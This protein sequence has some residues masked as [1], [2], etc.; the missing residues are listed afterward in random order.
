MDS[1]DKQNVNLYSKLKENTRLESAFKKLIVF[2]VL[3]CLLA[4]ALISCTTIPEYPADGIRVA[5]IGDSITEGFLMPNKKMYNYPTQLD[6]LLDEK[7][8][9]ENFGVSGACVMGQANKPYVSLSEYE[10]SVDFFP[11]IVF[12]MLGSNDSKTFNWNRVAFNIDYRALVAAY[13]NLPS[14][15]RVIIMT[16]IPAYSGAYRIQGDVIQNEIVPD[17]KQICS[18]MNIEMIDLNK[19]FTGRKEL[20]IIDGLHL[21][22]H[23]GQYMAK[24]VFESIDWWNLLN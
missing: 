18:E 9:V 14:K 23:G 21:N 24:T 19:A 11:D 4:A 2:P 10:K 20:Y 8:I 6:E 1:I 15:P 5:C 16:S 22:Q 3:I 12:F 13:L 17:V 7:Y